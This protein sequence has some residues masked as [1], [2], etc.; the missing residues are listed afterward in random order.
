MHIP[1]KRLVTTSAAVGL[2]VGGGLTGSF[3]AA[4]PASAASA[5]SARVPGRLGA[6]ERGARAE[7]SA[8]RTGSACPRPG[9]IEGS[10]ASTTIH[11]HSVLIGLP[12]YNP[13]RTSS[14]T[15]TNNST[16]S[17]LGGLLNNA[18]SSGYPSWTATTASTSRSAGAIA[19]VMEG[20]IEGSQATFTVHHHSV[21][22]GLPGYNPDR[23][24]SD[25]ITNNSTRSALGGLLNRASAPG[26]PSW[27][28][29]SSGAPAGC[30]GG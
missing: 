25:T 5:A 16:R 19:P 23:T 9:A 7:P 14:D 15:I 24:S 3:L 27:A 30:R 2:A 8:A 26:Y 18:S 20:A 22:I 1:G 13:D 12:G 29:G 17:A 4:G 10:Q 11:H 6:S 21:L 28:S